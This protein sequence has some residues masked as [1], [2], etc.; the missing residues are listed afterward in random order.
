LAHILSY[1]I[2]NS[3]CINTVAIDF[4]SGLVVRRHTIGIP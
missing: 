2:K 4:N 3:H 1:N